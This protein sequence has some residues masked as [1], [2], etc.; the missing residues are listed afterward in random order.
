M[1][2]VPY[3]HKE[4]ESHGELPCPTGGTSNNNLSGDLPKYDVAAW[5][6]GY[7]EHVTFQLVLIPIKSIDVP[8]TR[9]L[10]PTRRN[11][12]GIVSEQGPSKG[13][14]RIGERSLK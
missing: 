4:I 5:Q 6:E 13:L 3:C 8:K 12:Q 9:L 7:S 11:Q 10:P 2:R 1:L 14:K